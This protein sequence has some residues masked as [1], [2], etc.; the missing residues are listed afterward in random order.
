MVSGFS[1]SGRGQY[2]NRV[3]GC[4]VKKKNCDGESQLVIGV[5]SHVY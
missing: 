4:I 5:P 3:I 1:V 2:A